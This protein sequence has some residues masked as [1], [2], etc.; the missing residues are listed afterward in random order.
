MCTIVPSLLGIHMCLIL[1]WI[2]VYVFVWLII[3]NLLHNS[4]FLQSAFS[5]FSHFFFCFF[6]FLLGYKGANSSRFQRRSIGGQSP[7]GL[8][9]MRVYCFLVVLLDNLFPHYL[10]ILGWCAYM[11]I[12]IWNLHCMATIIAHTEHITGYNSCQCCGLGKFHLC[13][14]NSAGRKCT[15]A[16]HTP[17]YVNLEL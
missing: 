9:N 10:V 12:C 14:G 3:K 5:L 7:S 16:H 6:K 1:L 2:Y 15:L 13:T 17:A 8:W 4:Q 11:Y